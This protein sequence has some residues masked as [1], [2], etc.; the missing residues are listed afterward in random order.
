MV[1]PKSIREWACSVALRPISSLSFPR[2]HFGLGEAPRR[3]RMLAPRTPGSSDIFQ[4]RTR[5]NAIFHRF[6]RNAGVQCPV[7]IGIGPFPR[8]GRIRVGNRRCCN[9]SF[10]KTRLAEPM[11]KMA[12]SVR[13]A[14][15]ATRE[16]IIESQEA[17]HSLVL[18]IKCRAPPIHITNVSAA[19]RGSYIFPTSKVRC[20]QGQQPRRM[21]AGLG[22]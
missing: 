12:S 11:S 10:D 7:G 1:Y 8:C 20:D 22:I 13:L 15:V 17:A 4:L 19:K 5:G 14:A 18:R 2:H 3:V 21:L 9:T 6:F 16:F